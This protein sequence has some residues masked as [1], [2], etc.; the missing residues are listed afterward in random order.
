MM[1]RSF[2]RRFDLIRQCFQEKD[3]LLLLFQG[4]AQVAKFIRIDR[5]GD[6]RIRPI[7]FRNI[8][9]IVEVDDVVNGGKKPVVTIRRR[10]G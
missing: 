1:R 10:A 9:G 3:E 6:F 4:Q 5:C 8:P 2:N 7:L